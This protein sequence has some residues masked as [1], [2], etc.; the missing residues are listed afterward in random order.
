MDARATAVEDGRYRIGAVE[1]LT[2]LPANTLR[3]WERRYSVVEPVRS[4]GGTRLYSDWDVARL[5]VMVALCRVGETIG[6]IASLSL[7][8]LRERLEQ[9]AAPAASAGATSDRRARVALLHDT[10]GEQ[11]RASGDS[12]FVVTHEAVEL[13][14]FLQRVRPPVDVVVLALPLLGDWPAGAVQRCLQVTGASMAMVHVDFAPRATLQVL[15]DAGARLWVG[16]IRVTSLAGALRDHVL[17]EQIVARSSPRTPRPAVFEG[18][19]DTRRFSDADL[20]RYRELTLGPACECP[21]HL[22]LL[23]TQLVAFERY[24]RDCESRDPADADL[25]ASLAAGAGNARGV[26]EGLLV[27]VLHADGLL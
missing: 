17:T 11:I 15:G 2:G 4:D 1:R 12:S 27:R 25:H 18:S 7:E 3:T 9:H 24:S 14:A 22:A 16:P 26:L 20:A 6:T 5:Q 13:E 10:L 23:I 19:A 21:N 8:D